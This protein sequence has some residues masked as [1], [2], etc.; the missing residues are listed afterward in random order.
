MGCVPNT[1]ER[2]EIMRKKGNERTRSR[3]NEKMKE[4]EEDSICFEPEAESKACSPS[5]QHCT[6]KTPNFQSKKD[7]IDSLNHN[8]YL[9]VPLSTP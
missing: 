2:E 9:D 3:E 5:L 4:K 7:I 6:N 8:S 1:G